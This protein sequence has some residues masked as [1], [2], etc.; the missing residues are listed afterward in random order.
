MNSTKTLGRILILAIFCF[1]MGMILWNG[2]VLA[3]STT[4]AAVTIDKIQITQFDSSA[5]KGTLEIT[6]KKTTDLN[7][8]IYTIEVYVG[9]KAGELRNLKV[10]EPKE[11]S[12]A[13][14]ETKTINFVYEF[15][16]N[17][18][19]D[20][21]QIHINVYSNEGKMAYKIEPLGKLCGNNKLTFDSRG[22]I[23]VKDEKEFA[24][25]EEIPPF[26]IGETVSGY[27][28]VTNVSEDIYKVYPEIKIFLS[29]DYLNNKKEPL[30]V[31]K[32]TP[33]E[34]KPSESRKFDLAFE[35]QDVS[36]TFIVEITMKDD[37]GEPVSETLLYGYMI[38]PDQ[39][40]LPESNLLMKDLNGTIYDG[41]VSYLIREGIISGYEDGTFRPYNNIT[42]A[43]FAKI[44][45]VLFKNLPAVV[46]T[47]TTKKFKDVKDDH[48]A[49]EYIDKAVE[50]QLIVGYEDGTFRPEANITYGEALTILV[51]GMGLGEETEKNKQWPNNYYQ[52]AGE[53]N[54]ICDCIKEKVK[55]D[56]NKPAIR[57]DIAILA[58]SVLSN[59]S[60]QY[61]IDN[62]PDEQK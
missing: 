50:N 48:W 58:G 56:L 60:K 16:E 2:D 7:N 61:T 38:K 27:V 33:N 36:G 31:I 47:K 14:L 49:A 53:L 13:A 6:N 30:K 12:I 25:D 21:Y 55:T 15:P 42:R 10:P 59:V 9:M 28:T 37:K 52:K 3:D 39:D 11:L 51:R 17:I 35:K 29:S 46:Q 57:G 8:M 24:K 45:S 62:L 41:A 32:S 34:L 44:C 54:I 43:E 23:L 22:V 4:P 1:S 20:Y 18:P 19:T 26:S 5:V 40:A